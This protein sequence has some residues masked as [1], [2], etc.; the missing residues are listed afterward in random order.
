MFCD[1]IIWA[2]NSLGGST[3]FVLHPGLYVASLLGQMYFMSGLKETPIFP[4]PKRQADIPEY[5]EVSP[6]CTVRGFLAVR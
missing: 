4:N 2:P 5:L 3:P 1:V 6:T